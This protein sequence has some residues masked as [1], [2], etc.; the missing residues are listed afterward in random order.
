MT[1]NYSTGLFRIWVVLSLLWVI[2]TALLGGMTWRALIGPP[3]ILGIILY[4]IVWIIRGFTK[5]PPL[6]AQVFDLRELRTRLVSA[7]QAQDPELYK[8]ELEPLLDRLEAK[9]GNDIPETELEALKRF[10]KLKI[11]G[12]EKQKRE[13]IARGANCSACGSQLVEDAAF[14]SECGRSVVS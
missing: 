5:A 8:R 10:T 9:Y 12:L 13:I 11:V 6:S 1:F 2:A 7:V 4:L 14:C 3:L